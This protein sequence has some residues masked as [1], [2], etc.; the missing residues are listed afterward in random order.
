MT[1]QI[2]V[3]C[4]SLGAEMS[5]RGRFIL[6][7]FT[8]KCIIIISKPDFMQ[9]SVLT[10]HIVYYRFLQ[11]SIAISKFDTVF[12]IFVKWSQ[13]EEENMT[14]MYKR[15]K[16]LCEEN[17]MTVSQMCK[18]LSITRSCL[19]ELSK[20]RTERLSAENSTKIA[21]RFGVSVQYLI[22]GREEDFD[23]KLKYALF[24][25]TLG[26]TDEMFDEVKQ[27]AEMVML[28]E[29]AKRRKAGEK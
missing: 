17:H 13:L 22:S 23:T 16:E 9:I 20:G 18:E 1:F 5:K 29:E 6:L 28:R 12:C 26:V 4:I 8:G 25:G 24:N 11:K 2:T 10:I 3:F 14:E 15:I 7:T 19:S 27:Y 21:N